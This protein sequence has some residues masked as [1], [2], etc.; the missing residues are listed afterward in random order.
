MNFEKYPQQS[1]SGKTKEKTSQESLGEILTSFESMDRPAILQYQVD[2][3]IA[4]T[5]LDELET[6]ELYHHVVNSEVEHKAWSIPDAS[7][8]AIMK[9][10]VSR[11]DDQR[12]HYAIAPFG[13]TLL[14]L[15]WW[16]LNCQVTASEFVITYLS[17]KAL[18]DILEMSPPEWERAMR[19]LLEDSMAH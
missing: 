6:N 14:D 7:T 16:A 12:T 3:L 19:T 10:T 1:I 18:I 5:L 13:E 9:I 4:E 15:R 17:N 8:Q 2:S 11:E